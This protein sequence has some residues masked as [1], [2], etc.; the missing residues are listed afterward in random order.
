MRTSL[1]LSLHYQKAD[2]IHSEMYFL[3]KSSIFI[4]G[5][6]STQTAPVVAVSGV[7]KLKNAPTKF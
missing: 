1:L 6:I 7:S 2:E 4:P 5:D 3:K